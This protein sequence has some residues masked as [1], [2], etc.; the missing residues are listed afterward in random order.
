MFYAA[1]TFALKL[2]QSIALL[3]FTVFETIGKDA[4]IGYRIT[5]VVSAAVCILGGVLFMLY[6]EKKVYS[7]ISK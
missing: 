1:R 4:G 2:G 6:N 3:M 5:A 7:K